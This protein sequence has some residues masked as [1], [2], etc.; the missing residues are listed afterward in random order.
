M[1]AWAA[2]KPGTPMVRDS[3]DADLP[4]IAAIYGHHVVHGF[5]SFE[6]VPPDVGE[7]ARRRR[8]ILDKRLPYLVASDGARAILGYAYASPYRTRPAYR[9]TVEDSIYVAPEAA[10]RGVGRLLLQALIDRC[11]LLG[12]RQM[13][14]VIG[15]S[16]NAGSIGLHQALGFARAALLATIGF[17]RGRWV[18]CVMMQRGLGPGAGAPPVEIATP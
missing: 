16:G 17:K 10:R 15:D 1:S 11:T 6:E 5:G 12:Y 3:E 13:V 8:E 2:P 18:D 7:L 9:F 14:A 4:A